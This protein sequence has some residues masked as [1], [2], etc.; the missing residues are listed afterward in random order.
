MKSALTTLSLV[1]LSILPATAFAQS[2]RPFVITEEGNRVY[3]SELTADRQG[4]LSLTIGEGRGTRRFKKGNYKAAYVPRPDEVRK[5][6]AAF[7]K[8][9]FKYIDENADK[10][11]EQYG[12]L[13]W[14][15]M[16]MYIRAKVALDRNKPQQALEY[17]KQG[18]EYAS[19]HKSL[20]ARALAE[21]Y[22]AL[23]D[24]GKAERQISTVLSETDKDSTLAAMFNLKGDLRA[25]QGRK[26]EAVLEYMKTVLLFDKQSAEKNYEQARENMVEL[27]KDMNDRRYQNFENL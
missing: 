22:V 24:Y 14:G 4:S 26:K 25:A 8:G 13:G 16:I 6:Q 15:D 12:Y 9:E 21:T 10:V 1:L 2:R 11:L 20:T 7:S 5:L 27:M 23:K 19:I 3:G 18:R 17:L